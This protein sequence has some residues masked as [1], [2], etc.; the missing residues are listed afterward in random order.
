[1]G[2]LCTC[3]PVC[4]P[5]VIR[6]SIAVPSFLKLKSLSRIRTRWSRHE[7]KCPSVSRAMSSRSRQAADDVKTVDSDNAQIELIPVPCGYQVIYLRTWNTRSRP[8]IAKNRCMWFRVR[9][10]VFTGVAIMLF[11]GSLL[12]SGRH[13]I[14][15]PSFKHITT[16]IKTQFQDTSEGGGGGRYFAGASDRQIAIV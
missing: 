5:I 14:Y 13:L 6:F 1:M 12:P 2:I 8:D 10:A 9:M 16:S 3:L 7:H 11:E 15:L 4:W